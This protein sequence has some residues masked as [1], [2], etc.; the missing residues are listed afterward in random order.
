[1][2]PLIALEKYGD[3]RYGFKFTA[4]NIGYH[5]NVYDFP[6]FCAF[7]LKRFRAGFKP[8]EEQNQ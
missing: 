3:I 5:Q 7:L 4:G 1:M 8:V 6:Y 2:R